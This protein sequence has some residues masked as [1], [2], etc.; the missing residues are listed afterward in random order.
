M[1]TKPKAWRLVV[2]EYIKSE[3]VLFT[4]VA[5]TH[6]HTVARE[7]GEC[8]AMSV[9]ADPGVPDC[10]ADCEEEKEEAFGSLTTSRRSP[11]SQTIMKLMIHKPTK[12][13][14]RNTF[15]SEFDIINS[16]VIK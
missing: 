13:Y 10:L 9:H 12:T 3:P 7:R 1:L 16:L 4:S 5:L 11:E 6:K 8:K 2:V 15:L 14:S